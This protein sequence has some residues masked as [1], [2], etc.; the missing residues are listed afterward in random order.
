MMFI[1]TVSVPNSPGLD[2]GFGP[3]GTWLAPASGHADLES[4]TREMALYADVE[5]VTFLVTS[6]P[7]V[8]GDLEILG[9]PTVDDGLNHTAEEILAAYP[10]SVGD[11]RD[12]ITAYFTPDQPT[13]G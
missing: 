8:L 11:V 5:N 10:E 2:P 4:V 9:G 1:L 6:G 7:A 13:A 3:D 12:A